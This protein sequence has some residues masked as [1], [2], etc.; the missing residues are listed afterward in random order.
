MARPK[1]PTTPPVSPSPLTAEEQQAKI[2]E[3]ILR[4]LEAI[5]ARL[6][7]TTT[8][9]VVHPAPAAPQVPEELRL[10]S[11]TTTVVVR[12]TFLTNPLGHLKKWWHDNK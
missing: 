3:E 2:N 10:E 11:T 8:P 12:N 6:A 1:Q 4:R 9:V 7:P 5:D